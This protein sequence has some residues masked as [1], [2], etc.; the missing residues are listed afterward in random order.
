MLTLKLN[1]ILYNIEKRLMGTRTAIFK[2]IH[3]VYDYSIIHI[4]QKISKVYASNVSVNNNRM[5]HIKLELFDYE[6][7]G[8]GIVS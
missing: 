6:L 1:K 7:V 8:R 3:F 5:N 2:T 4:L